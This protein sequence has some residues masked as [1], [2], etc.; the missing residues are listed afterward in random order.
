MAVAAVKVAAMKVT[1]AKTKANAGSKSE[2]GPVVA[3]VVVA[4][5]VVVADPATH[6]VSISPPAAPICRL[7]DS[8]CC[9]GFQFAPRT[10]QRGRRCAP[11]ESPT[12]SRN[13]HRKGKASYVHDDLLGSWTPN[14]GVSAKF[15]ISSRD[16]KRPAGRL[17]RPPLRT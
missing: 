11:R 6:A 15:P 14:A 13:R 10:R 5:I 12:R 2:V 1:A 8:R 4:V 16:L 17:Y 7:F 3:I 9:C